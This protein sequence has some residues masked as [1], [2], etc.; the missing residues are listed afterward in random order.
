MPDL[1]AHVGEREHRDRLVRLAG[2]DHCLVQGGGNVCHRLDAVAWLLGQTSAHDSGK[3]RGR[4]EGRG[5]VVDHRRH[6]RKR[7]ISSK[8][9]AATQYLVE[10]RAEEEHIRARV[11]RRR[12]VYLGQAEVEQLGSRLVHK[13]VGRLQVAMHDTF[14]M[15]GGQCRGDLPGQ[16][17]RVDDRLA[18]RGPSTPPPCH[19]RQAE[20][21][22][23]R[24]QAGCREPK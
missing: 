14:P 22:T 20:R 11:H 6:D 9:A 8:S 23:R 4:V 19:P 10:H 16:P 21:S 2:F 15:G 13:N 7:R 3:R 24:G 12:R 1:P 17:Q 5:R 18:C